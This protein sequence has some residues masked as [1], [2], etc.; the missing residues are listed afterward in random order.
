M[1]ELIDWMRKRRQ[2]D[3]NATLAGMI[4]KAGLQITPLSEQRLVDLACVD[5]MQR[6]RLGAAVPINDYLRDFTVL[7]CRSH[8]LDLIDADLCVS[9]E[10][11][12]PPSIDRYVKQF[13]HLAREI[14]DLAKMASGNTVA[15]IE[16]ASQVDQKATD[17]D[18]PE[19]LG[20]YRILR[21]LGFG[22]MGT[23]YQARQ[24]SLDRL[25]A[26]K[27]IR[28]RLTENA[29]SMARFAREAYAAAQLTHH[30]VIQIYDFGEDNGQHFF[31]MEWVRGGTLDKLVRQKGPLR[32]KLAAGYTL[33]AARG[34][35]FAHQHG[36]VHRDVKPA[37]LLLSTEGVV[38]LADLGL[39]KVPNQIDIG[40]DQL[41]S[42][43]MSSV[44]HGIQ[45]GTEVTMQ[46]TA[47]GTPA[48]M[49]PEQGNDSTAVDHRADIYA[50]G[51]TLFYLLTGQPPFD[52]KQTSQLLE[53]HASSP[54][55][56]LH[57]LN[58]KIPEF[59]AQIVARAMQKRPEDRYP[60]AAAMAADLESFLS[61][62]SDRKFAPTRKQAD[63]WALIAK[64]YDE[65]T[66]ALWVSAPLVAGLCAISLLTTLGLIWFS[67]AGILFG[68]AMFVV[69]TLTAVFMTSLRGQSA[70]GDQI[71]AW[72]AVQSW[73][74]YGLALTALVS[75]VLVSL[76]TGTWIG[77]LVG[78]LL[79][80]ALGAAYE[81]LL[82]TPV[83]QQ[84]ATPL[85]AAMRFVREMRMIGTPE[86]ELRNFVAGQSGKRGRDLVEALFGY[87][88]L[89][90]VRPA[91]SI[92]IRDR[93]CAT[94]A[95]KTAA[96]RSVSDH[97]RLA[98]IEQRSLREEG[99][100]ESEA[101]DKAWQ[102]AAAVMEG[103]RSAAVEVSGKQ[104]TGKQ[105]AEIKRQRIKA[106]LADARSGKYKQQKDRRAPW[107]AAFSGQ[108]RLMAGCLLL[109][110]FAIAGRAS[111]LFDAASQIDMDRELLTQSD[112]WE[113]IKVH[114]SELRIG[115]A[116][117]LLCMSAFVSGWRMTPFAVVATLVILFGPSIG[118]PAAGNG[119]QP[120]MMS[121]LIG[122]MVYVPGV[123]FGEDRN[124]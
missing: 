86:D 61:I 83:R 5:L 121:I 68:P 78:T 103:A 49:A 53:Q 63:Q 1:D 111:G 118:I 42:E 115:I 20:G 113:Q 107:R 3:P 8:Q 69:A 37:N 90:S 75:V 93:I 28:G 54:I 79:G 98:K 101:R 24:L 7:N 87:E 50:L 44:A 47:V 33:Q 32:P 21:M 109:V 48:F 76:L 120:W 95:R 13:P 72:L 6:R 4:R 56:N 41:S 12:H 97:Q 36:M 122:L 57:H 39:V 31:S 65:A 80:V 92:S 29:S 34:L 52:A 106:M 14:K 17:A 96:K 84:Q 18:A 59:L 112:L 38:K 9:V 55:P 15:T 46:G 123:L 116:G 73:H 94:L 35:Q 40:I 91:F 124:P 102:M 22:A 30:N 105:A 23:V 104:A 99:L 2:V 77:A 71:R 108:S 70:V 27:T 88:A 11:N 19:R 16:T 114:Q 85:A 74:D 81:F 45:S 67:P 43:G 60:S 89:G 10:L 110:W 51:C 25:V 62:R 117:L 100:S 66:S 58:A 64:Q 82:L 119:V 26:L